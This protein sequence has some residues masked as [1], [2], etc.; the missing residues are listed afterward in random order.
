LLRQ[1]RAGS[2]RARGSARDPARAETVTPSCRGDP[3]RGRLPLPLARRGAPP[4][5]AKARPR[6][7][8]PRN[9]EARSPFGSAVYG[10]LED[11][12]EAKVP[13]PV[14]NRIRGPGGGREHAPGNAVVHAQQAHGGTDAKAQAVAQLE[15]PSLFRRK[16][17]EHV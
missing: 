9:G 14:G 12:P 15:G 10:L 17:V 4:H 11:V 5:R 6:R 2:A 16:R 13:A 3:S 7:E 1:A 8:A